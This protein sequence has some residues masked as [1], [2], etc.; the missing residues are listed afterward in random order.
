[1]NASVQLVT[2]PWSGYGFSPGASALGLMGGGAATPVWHGSGFN[3]GSIV[4]FR[5][6]G[7][8]ATLI[9]N[10][11]GTGMTASFV[12]RFPGGLRGLGQ[13][14]QVPCVDDPALD[15]SDPTTGGVSPPFIDISG[16]TFPGNPP[17][18]TGA[19]S[20]ISTALAQI[21]TPLSK[22]TGAIAQQYVSYQ[23]PLLQKQTVALSP[24][25]QVLYATNQPTAAGATA[26]AFGSITPLL[27]VGLVAAVVM[28]VAAKK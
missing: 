21:F 26:S 2:A 5:S 14:V 10:P 7:P 28:G 19:P 15:C 11:R 27:L 9:Q 18:V 25:G 1:M 13:G 24:S 3:W 23:N 20:G 16:P 4:G 17:T 6:G 22:A 8:I 12:R